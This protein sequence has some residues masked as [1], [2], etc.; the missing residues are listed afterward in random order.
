MSCWN[1]DKSSIQKW[2][3]THDRMLLPCFVWEKGK[4]MKDV[5]AGLTEQKLCIICMRSVK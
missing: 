1:T 4:Q 5:G 2:H 3:Q